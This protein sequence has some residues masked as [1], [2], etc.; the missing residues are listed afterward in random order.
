MLFTLARGHEVR[1]RELADLFH[2]TLPGVGP[3][4]A[5]VVCTLSTNGKENENGNPEWIGSLRAMNVLLCPQ[6]A[7]AMYLVTRNNIQ[8]LAHSGYQ[9]SFSP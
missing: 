7:L 8:Q 6:G 9:V 4:T 3:D 1:E 2:Y 5:T